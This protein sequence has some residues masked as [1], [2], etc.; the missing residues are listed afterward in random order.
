MT[1]ESSE[2]YRVQVAAALRAGRVCLFEICL[3]SQTF[4]LLENAEAVFGVSSAQILADL[5][6]FQSLSPEEF[7]TAVP[8]YFSHKDDAHALAQGFEDIR[9]GR[10]YACTARMRNAASRQYRRCR[11]RMAPRGMPQPTHLVGAIIP[12]E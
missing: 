4:T 8:Q 6:D 5:A 10:R 11:I 1:P 2:A 7:R 12:E 9:A 3:A